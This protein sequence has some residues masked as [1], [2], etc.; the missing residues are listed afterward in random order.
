MERTKDLQKIKS[1]KTTVLVHYHRMAEYG[2]FLAV[3]KLTNQKSFNSWTPLF[4][5]VVLGSNR[6]TR[7][8]WWEVSSMFVVVLLM[9]LLALMQSFLNLVF[10]RS[11]VKD[12]YR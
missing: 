10:V 6:F 4:A 3:Y 12:Y 8:Q 2:L 1:I 7:V 11:V 5:Y 9:L